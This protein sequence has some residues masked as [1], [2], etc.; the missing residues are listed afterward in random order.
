VRYLPCWFA[1]RLEQLEFDT[2][3]VL[4]LFLMDMVGM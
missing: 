2:I 3:F 4:V 1:F